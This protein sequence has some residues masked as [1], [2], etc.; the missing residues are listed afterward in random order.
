MKKNETAKT[1]MTTGTTENISIEV[2]LQGLASI[3]KAVKESIA[4][5]SGNQLRYLVDS[6]YQ[7]QE[8]RK[9]LDNQLR[10]IEQG[11]DGENATPLA[12]KWLAQ[13]VKNQENQIKK[14]LDEY[15]DQSP[16]TRWAKATIG[17]GPVIAA[18][19]VANFDISK[20]KYVNQ[21]YS[22][23]GLNNN[24]SPWLGTDKAKELV[25]VIYSYDELKIK[26]MYEA[27]IIESRGDAVELI[28]DIQ[29]AA[30]YYGSEFKSKVLMPYIYNNDTNCDSSKVYKKFIK[31][32]DT[33]K[34]KCP[35]TFVKLNSTSSDGLFRGIEDLYLYHNP[36]EYIRQLPMSHIVRQQYDKW[37][38][39]L[40]VSHNTTDAV[41]PFDK[42]AIDV[43]CDMCFSNIKP[44]SAGNCGASVTLK[45]VTD[46]IIDMI[47]TATFRSINSIN[48]MLKGDRT[49]NNLKTQLAKP[50][51]NKDLAVLCWKI[52]DS[53]MK[54]SGNEN[55]LYGRLYRERKALEIQ[56][57]NAGMYADQA[58]IQ[59]ESKNYSKGT[60]TYEALSQGKLSDAQINE[61][62]KRWAVK[63]FISHMYEIMYM[64]YYKEK[65]PIY[66]TLAKDPE[67][68][69]YIGPEVPFE[70]YITLD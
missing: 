13:N 65:P 25:D 5:V 29:D 27:F 58:K 44:S 24:N 14:M 26:L 33:L 42:A 16:V 18:G 46:H 43:F 11:V 30:E 31:A 69:K 41:N 60:T 57:N 56:R 70:D 51:F 49:I 40:K 17:I 15:T 20:V 9:A 64:D 62:A 54:R 4:T 50:P 53:F 38:K 45:I 7:T 1:T 36:H 63:L 32:M 22:Y 39:Q 3:S 19:L 55:S 37:Q 28:K 2:D 48:G 34:S 35:D 66:Y 10:S 61:R 59:L 68:N 52:G 23:C 8:Y 12:L 21:F 67:H 6:Y 47:A